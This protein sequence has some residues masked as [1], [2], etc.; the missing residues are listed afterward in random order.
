MIFLLSQVSRPA[1]QPAQQSG[2]YAVALSQNVKW[3]WHKSDYAPP[4]GAEVRN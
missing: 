4:S 1:L 2:D 3:P